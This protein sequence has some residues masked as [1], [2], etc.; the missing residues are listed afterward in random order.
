MG[1]MEES[2]HAACS[3]MKLIS[4]GS[5]AKIGNL[6]RKCLRLLYLRTGGEEL[7]TWRKWKNVCAVTSPDSNG[8]N[9]AVFH[10]SLSRGGH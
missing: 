3:C 10:I 8:S 4:V 1:A 7:E 2:F 9:S 5:Q 6:E